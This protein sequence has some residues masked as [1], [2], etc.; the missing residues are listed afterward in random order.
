MV[1]PETVRARI[2]A[3]IPDAERV[4]VRDLTGTRDHYEAVVVAAS[5]AGLSR[6]EQHQRV[7]RALGELMAGDVHALA[8]VT[9]TPETAR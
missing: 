5:F 7:Y 2:L 1:E 3:A 9:R 4:D 8:L 6:I